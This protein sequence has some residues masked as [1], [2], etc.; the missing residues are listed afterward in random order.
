MWFL[1]PLAL[2]AIVAGRILSTILPTSVCAGQCQV[3][4]DKVS[5]K[6]P[7]LLLQKSKFIFPTE[8]VGFRKNDFQCRLLLLVRSILK[9][10][11]ERVL[12]FKEGDSLELFCHGGSDE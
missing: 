8:K 11:D 4:L 9:V 7:P 5:G 2:P 6:F 3:N 1:L 10:K 12:N